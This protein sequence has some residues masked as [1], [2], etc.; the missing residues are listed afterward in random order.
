MQAAA[1][2]GFRL[3]VPLRCGGFL[4]ATCK[5]GV[6]SGQIGPGGSATAFSSRASNC[7]RNSSPISSKGSIYPQVLGIYVKKGNSQLLAALKAALE[8]FKAS[9]EYAKLLKKYNLEEA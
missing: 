8:Q 3:P 1:A 5:F 9:G 2:F 7:L 6:H 4:S